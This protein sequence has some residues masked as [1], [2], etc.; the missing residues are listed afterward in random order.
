MRHKAGFYEKYVKTISVDATDVTDEV[1][2]ELESD[3]PAN[4]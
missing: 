2:D 1:L 4:D 3:P